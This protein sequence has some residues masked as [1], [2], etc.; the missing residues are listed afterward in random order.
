MRVGQWPPP[1]TGFRLQVADD[2]STSRFGNAPKFDEV[3]LIGAVN[4]ELFFR[5][6]LLGI[7]VNHRNG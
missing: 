1:R 2:V 4:D 5:F 6:I 3:L 7:L